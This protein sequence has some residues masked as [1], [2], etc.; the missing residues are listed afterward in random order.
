MAFDVY[1]LAFGKSLLFSLATILPI[2]NPP[3][4]APMFLM[5]TEG[6]SDLTRAQLALRIATNVFIMV[7][8]AMLVG[9]IVLDFFGISLAIVRVGG[10]LLVVSA[11]WKLLNTSDG[12]TGS[13]ARLAEAFTPEIA[14]SKAFYPLTFP[15]TCG[16]G[17][18][19]ASI[20]VGASL[21]DPSMAL[22]AARMMGA[23]LGVVV[24][25]SVLFLCFRFANQ[26]LR[27]LGETG[28]IVLLRMSAFILLCLGVQIVWEGASELILSVLQRA[29]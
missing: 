22:S 28:T 15:I 11:A 24:I 9:S 12:G 1:L 26:L 13:S 17:T 3:S 8:V 20:T 29:A 7:V 23:M 21:H 4:A 6:A 10:G 2:L 5:L 27:P 18:V 19:A 16:P 25:S 14:R